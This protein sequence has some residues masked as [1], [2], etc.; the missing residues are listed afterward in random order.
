[1]CL[2]L[3]THPDPLALPGAQSVSLERFETERRLELVPP[4]GEFAVMNYRSTHPFK[5]P[6]RMT[7]TVEDDPNSAFKARACIPPPPCRHR[8]LSLS[9]LSSL[10]QPFAP[11]GHGFRVCCKLL[12]SVTHIT[13]PRELPHLVSAWPAQREAAANIPACANE[14]LCSCPARFT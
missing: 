3:K 9:S 6:F 8:V 12:A 1:M 4:D 2:L 14:Q 10:A 7:C 11:A 13:A 5:L